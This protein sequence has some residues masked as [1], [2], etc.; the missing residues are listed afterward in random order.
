MIFANR[1]VDGIAIS[2]KTLYR[3][4]IDCTARPTILND[5]GICQLKETLRYFLGEPSGYT[6]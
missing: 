3:S 5:G 2:H 4:I 1:H 6:K